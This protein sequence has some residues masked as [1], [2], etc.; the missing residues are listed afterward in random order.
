MP[1]I[2][3]PFFTRKERGKGTGLGLSSVYGI[4][5]QS[6]GDIDV[7]S[8]L[9]KGTSFFLRFPL[10]APPEHSTD[11]P[12]EPQLP[13]SG[14]ILLVD[15]DELVRGV[16]RAQLESAGYDVKVASSADEALGMLDH[17]STFDLL[18]SDV[19]MPRVTGVE[20]ARRTRAR[21]G[22]LPILLVSG[23][24]AELS[25][26]TLDELNAR[27]LHKPFGTKQLLTAVAEA[28]A[29]R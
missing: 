18:V 1:R 9:G 20:L 5:R 4:V 22:A 25:P 17:G 11:A 19:I 21:L 23:Y 10:S 12:S 13:G 2:F 8:T 29:G 6:Q 14:R 7:E 26:E 3:E 15:D 24:A 16:V 27:L 28:L